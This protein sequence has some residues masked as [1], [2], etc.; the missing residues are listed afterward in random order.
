MIHS[1]DAYKYL[2]IDKMNYLYFQCQ[3]YAN[4]RISIEHEWTKVDA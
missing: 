2:K 4:R 1:L 3:Y